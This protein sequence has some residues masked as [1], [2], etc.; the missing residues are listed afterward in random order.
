MNTLTSFITSQYFGRAHTLLLRV[1]ALPSNNLNLMLRNT[2]VLV[3]EGV[4]NPSNYPA[5][6]RH[7]QVC[8]CGGSTL[9][10]V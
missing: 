9:A 10:E 4:L 3:I 7:R 6:P 2:V 8:D 5:I 1:V